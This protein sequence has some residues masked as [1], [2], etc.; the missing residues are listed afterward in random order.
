[1]SNSLQP[2]EL[3]HAMLPVF[4]CLPEFA[5][6]YVHWVSDG[7]PTSSSV[8][9]LLFSSVFPSIRVF[10]NE[11]APLLKWPKYWSFSTSPSNEYSGLISF[12]IEWLHLLAIQGTQESSAP[13]WKHQFFGTQLSLRSNFHIFLAALWGMGDLSSPTRYWTQA[14]CSR[15]RAF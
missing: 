11:L 7:H 4:H 12:R 5:Q 3:Q 14:L 1:M 10:F 15:S 8:A 6:I 2:H 9:P 13:V